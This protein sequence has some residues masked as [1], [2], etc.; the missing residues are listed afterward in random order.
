MLQKKL[1]KYSINYL[2]IIILLTTFSLIGYVV[3]TSWTSSIETI[4]A[5]IQSNTN[6]RLLVQIDQFINNPLIINEANRSL[7]EQNIIDLS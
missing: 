4:I 3:F 6:Q 1:L 7:L 2:F 5:D